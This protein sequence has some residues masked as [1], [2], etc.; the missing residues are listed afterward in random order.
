MPQSI[1]WE[2]SSNT[3]LSNMPNITNL[4][5]GEYIV[6]TTCG[7]TCLPVIDTIIVPDPPILIIPGIKSDISCFG[8]NDGSIN[9][10]VSGLNPLAVSTQWS[11]PNGFNSILEDI[12]TLSAG[13][14]S[15]LVTDANNCFTTEDFEV[16]EPDSILPNPNI[17]AV[18]CSGQ[19]T[20]TAVLSP[21]GGI[22]PYIEYW[23]TAI[24]SDLY[25]GT[26]TYS[27]TDSNSCVYLGEVIIIEPDPILPNPIIADV[28]CNGDSTGITVL[29]PTGGT[30]PY[31]INWGTNNPN[32]LPVG[33][34]LYTITDNNNCPYSDVVIISQ[35]NP[36]IV[37]PTQQNLSCY[38]DFN[39]WCTISVIG[40]I[41]PYTVDW[42]GVDSSSLSAGTYMYSVS[43]VNNCILSDSVIITEPD[44]LNV[45]YTTT[46][47]Q[48]YSEPTG[49][50]DIN[51][52]FVNPPYSY[53]W[54]NTS[55]PSY[56]ETVEDVSNL[57]AGA[58][59]LTVV[60]ADLCAIELQIIVSQPTPIS[61][62]L[63][64]E[65]SNYNG[66]NIACK[67]E[68]SGWIS[69]EVSGGY[70][71]FT[72]A[73]NTGESTDS[74]SNLYADMY[75]VTVTD[76]L[77]CSLNLDSIILTEPDTIL[78]GVIQATTDYNGFNISCFNGLDGGIREIPSGGVPPYTWFWDGIQGSEYES[79][80]TA[81]YHN[82]ELY[83]NNNCLWENNIILTE[84]SALSIQNI[85][86]TDTCERAVGEIYINVS[87]GVFPYIYLWSSGQDSDSINNL[88]EG[89][90]TINSTDDNLCE[91]LDSISVLNLKIP[92]ADFHTYPDH[93]RFYDQLENPF[94][95]IDI[96]NTYLQ[97]II[98]WQWDFGDNTFGTDS[99]ASHSY[100]EVGEYTILL[101]IETQYNCWD[102]ISKKILIDEYD[103]YIPNAFTPLTG[104]KLNDEFKA[105]GYGIKNYTLKIYNRWGG[106]IFESDNINRGW[107]GTINDGG[108]MAP[109]GIYVYYIAVENIY[110]EIFKYEG[111][112]NLIR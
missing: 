39:G 75:N 68:N 74:I 91:I 25:A 107:D 2:N 72:Y 76:G 32:S 45:T 77:G 35:P 108:T 20:G 34:H 30:A 79:N 12:N 66:F 31:I 71:P 29:S 44:S 42:Y 13:L 73:W 101:T 23:G 11:S 70:I 21:T 111:Q 96:S 38:G 27:I 5:A 24:P 81:G 60:D 9:I 84:P 54:I 51:V 46:D 67:T 7:L 43:D 26:Y 64:I 36:I 22:T 94:L 14:Y 58:Y 47:V 53:L 98:D 99:I 17:T 3:F 50:I 86:V 97:N 4:I 80:K 1:I 55:N 59:L 10:T 87:G 90:Y 6:S 89:I 103:L 18:L 61:E 102:T 109:I 15:V 100:A 112:L 95:F 49:D 48:C 16:S 33:S 63:N 88:T 57:Y 28:L 93:R 78:T 56:M 69:L 85:S 65:S 106:I 52:L 110:G 104:D 82:V 37:S 40:G 41:S 92:E 62:Y 105:Y 19:N 8:L 83:D